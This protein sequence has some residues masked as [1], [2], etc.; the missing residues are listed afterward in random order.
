MP[1]TIGFL[2]A[3]G[4][5][6]CGASTPAHP[7]TPAHAAPAQKPPAP[8]LTADSSPP[9]PAE[10]A[11]ASNAPAPGA[12]LPPELEAGEINRG[13][14]SAVLSSGIGRFLQRLHA[15]PQLDKGRFLGWRLVSFAEGDATLRS[16]VLQPGDTVMRVNGQSIERPEQFKNVW[17]SM[18]TSS[19]L[20]LEVQRAGKRS[21]LHYRIVD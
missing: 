10:S 18:A 7:T 8:E 15:E 17:D 5:A 16:G 2:L 11:T 14:L 19:D 4:C 21:E 1:R 3:L 9:A 13:T 12:E 20:V 6:A